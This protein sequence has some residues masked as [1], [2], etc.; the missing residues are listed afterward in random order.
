MDAE[1][2]QEHKGMKISRVGKAH[3]YMI[4]VPAPISV[5]MASAVIALLRALQRNLVEMSGFIRLRYG[6]YA[7]NRCG[8]NSARDGNPQI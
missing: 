8:G 5:I 2:K 1:V 7:A 3:R 4:F 6:R